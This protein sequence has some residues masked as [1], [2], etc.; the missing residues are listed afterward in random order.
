M[1]AFARPVLTMEAVGP[2]DILTSATTTMER[3]AAPAAR[4]APTTLVQTAWCIAASNIRPKKAAPG[5]ASFV[6]GTSFHSLGGEKGSGRVGGVGGAPAADGPG[7]LRTGFTVL[8]MAAKILDD[9][10]AGFAVE[11]V[12]RCG[13]LGHFL[14]AVRAMRFHGFVPERMV[15]VR[16]V[17]PGIVVGC[18]VA[19]LKPAEEI[20]EV[21]VRATRDAAPALRLTFHECD[22]HGVR[23]DSGRDR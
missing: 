6:P 12:T 16:I 9:L 20:V 10:A 15:E 4:T 3:A 19:V 11:E 13:R 1:F 21:R 17:E 5:A 8:G 14:Q 7:E 23:P 22:L 2:P 18:A